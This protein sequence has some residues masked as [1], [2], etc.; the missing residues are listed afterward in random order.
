[1]KYAFHPCRVLFTIFLLLSCLCFCSCSSS[2]A[3]TPCQQWYAKLWVSVTLP[4]DFYLAHPHSLCATVSR[5]LIIMALL[6]YYHVTEGYSKHTSSPTPPWAYYVLRRTTATTAPPPLPHNPVDIERQ[7]QCNA[8]RKL[9]CQRRLIWSSILRLL[10]QSI[11]LSFNG[12][13]M[14]NERLNQITSC[15]HNRDDLGGHAELLLWISVLIWWIFLW[16]N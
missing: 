12:M 6:W 13:K 7:Q 14:K 1:M 11:K 8:L 9:H 15:Y 10:L 4:R 3:A 2:S 16:P 5:T